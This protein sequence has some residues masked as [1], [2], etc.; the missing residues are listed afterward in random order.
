MQ[1]TDLSSYDIYAYE[2]IDVTYKREWYQPR[3]L[4]MQRE[5][6]EGY[7]EAKFYPPDM[8]RTSLENNKPYITI[9]AKKFH[10]FKMIEIINEFT[11]KEHFTFV[12][13]FYGKGNYQR[14]YLSSNLEFMLERLVN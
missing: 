13:A 7:D 2:D 14:L 11:I 10:N 6:I 5:A 3:C 9:M 8:L 1:E 12:H 4:L